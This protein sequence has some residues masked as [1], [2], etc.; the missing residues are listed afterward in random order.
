MIKHQLGYTQEKGEFNELPTE[1]IPDM[2]LTPKELLE[3][4]TRGAIN[5]QTFFDEDND[6][7]VK[8]LDLVEIDQLRDELK[9]RAKDAKEKL[10]E[11]EHE[12][13]RVI[14]DMYKKNRQSENKENEEN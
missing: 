2:A 10:S 13:L 4:Y 5:N 11:L 3:N 7:N 8:G 9:E 14:N 6:W 1:T 12:R